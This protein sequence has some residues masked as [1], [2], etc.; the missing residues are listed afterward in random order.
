MRWF[1][2]S[3]SRRWFSES[4]KN[5]K[6]I[7]KNIYERPD[8]ET[9]FTVNMRWQNSNTT[10]AKMTSIRAQNILELTFTWEPLP[11]PIINPDRYFPIYHVRRNNEDGVDNGWKKFQQ[12][13]TR[14]LLLLN[15][16]CHRR[17]HPEIE[18]HVA[19]GKWK[20]EEN[21]GNRK[22]VVLGVAHPVRV[23]RLQ[24]TGDLV[25]G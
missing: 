15:I 10:D 3:D 2:Y 21:D 23:A 14:R 9:P 6:Q 4:A 20:A 22:A 7:F 25:D 18:E 11:T 8:A 19:K 16:L 1:S 12:K 5:A 17:F 13:S 24:P